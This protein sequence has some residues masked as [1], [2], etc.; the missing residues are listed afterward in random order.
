[1]AGKPWTPEELKILV[2]CWIQGNQTNEQIASQLPGRTPRSCESKID[3]MIADGELNPLERGKLSKELLAD[4]IFRILRDNPLSMEQL[5]NRLDLAPAPI[6]SALLDMEEYQG[7]KLI[8]VAGRVSIPTGNK[9]IIAPKFDSVLAD[10]GHEL[11]LGFNSDLHSTSIYSQ[12]T[13]HVEFIQWAHEV[14]HVKHFFNPGDT[15]EGFYG[16]KGQKEE[17]IHEAWPES[18]DMAWRAVDRQVAF[19]NMYYP[20]IDGV[21][22]YNLGGN[23]DWWHIAYT[24][25]DG[26]WLLCQ[27][28]D[29]MHYLGYDSAS[30]PI[31]DRAHLRLTHPTGGVPYAKSYRL[32][33]STEAQAI[34]A[35]QEAIRKEESPL[36]SIH[37]AGHLHIAVFLPT[38]PVVAAHVGTFQAQTS[39]LKRKYL[40][41]DLGGVVMKLT[42]GDDGRVGSVQYIWRP[43]MEI[44]NDWAAWGLPDFKEGPRQPDPIETIFS[45]EEDPKP[46]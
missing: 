20:K 3:K 15:F 18:R 32:Q 10:E 6:R 38:M 35:L 45:F 16:Y 26:N 30:V 12:P 36:V 34:E 41:P 37:V 40:M 11:A 7:Y 8:S 39:Y 42:V 23:H 5:C 25:R 9:P 46:K 27:R 17:V 1:M 33:K 14:H 19:A 31:T 44:K 29:D 4:K 21:E 22:Y 43:Y 2:A 28:R 13:S 24:G